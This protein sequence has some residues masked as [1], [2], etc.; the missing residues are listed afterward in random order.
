MT[1]LRNSILSALLWS[2]ALAAARADVSCPIIFSDHMVLQ[3]DRAVPM[4]GKAEAGEKV[5]V[6]FAGQSKSTAADVAG[7]WRVSL[8]P[9]SANA[10][11]RTLTVRGTNTLTFTDVLVG[12][13]W[14]CSG[15]S[16]MEKQLG[17]R[18]GQKPT[19][20]HEEEIRSA[21]HPLLRLYQV[22]QRGQPQG[23][24]TGLRWL[25]CT[26]ET[27]VSTEFSA[28]AYFFGRE[29]QHELGVPVGLI[30][31]SFGGT[32]IEAWMPPEAF[33]SDSAL[34]DLPNQKYQA[35]VRGVQATELYQSMV[36]PFVPFALRGFL[37]YQ[38]ETN[39]MN[40]DHLVYSTKMRA[41]IATWRSAWEIQDA[42]FYF[43]QLAP[44]FYSGQ[45]NWE[46][47]L[48]P[49]AL[50]ALWEAQVRA[51]DVPH[52]GLVV[53]TDLAG[54]GRDIHPTNKRDVGLRF[55]RLALARTYGRSDVPALSPQLLSFNRSW[56]G[57]KITLAFAQGEG[58]RS[59]DG[60]PLTG[61]TVAGK[62]RQ[63]HPATAVTVGNRLIVSS[64]AV[65]RPVAVRFAWH[66]LAMPNLVNAAGLPAVPFRTDDWP[67]VLEVA[68]ETPAK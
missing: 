5:T 13:V 1:A 68:K 55:A 64:R 41:L 66:E 12:E 6:E 54:N 57:R 11:S 42:P 19:D 56:F 27:V 31:S 62:D 26:P 21:D 22:T 10:E 3:R 49:D 63:F 38:G 51:L 45:K 33:A 8:D 37:W 43:A 40:A 61:F 15:Q 28:A 14:F 9:L 16:N 2:V 23:K 67:L 53:T 36:A 65:P 59:R 20:N 50:P 60:Q 4:W 25:A 29:L 32:R 44:F 17:P 52:T 24:I 48:T 7:A 58:L 39:C 30:H 47:H 18:R 35:W 46:K 34:Q